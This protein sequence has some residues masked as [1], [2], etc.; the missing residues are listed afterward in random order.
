MTADSCFE[1]RDAAAVAALP[2]DHP[3]RRHAR[4]CPRCA[5]LL[6][7]WRAF[8]A[9]DPGEVSARDLADADARLSRALASAIGVPATDAATSDAAASR[10]P[11]ARHADRTAPPT[12]RTVARDV[13][14]DPS[15]W[16]RLMHPALRPALSFAALAL[17]LGAVLLWPRLA[18]HG[19]DLVLRGETHAVTLA[20][21][22]TE[23]VGEALH[24]EWRAYPGAETYEL[25]FFSGGLA[26]LGR[27]GSL[28]GT[29]ADLP[30]A[31]LPFR[32]AAGE[33]VLVRVAAMSRGDAMATS[34]ARMV[35]GR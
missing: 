22:R 6:D 2:D 26:E 15:F 13:G 32:F 16:E 21:L 17:V 5:A 20:L 8:A 12:G 23:R 3:Q 10:E 7:A 31:G 1:A 28:H 24:L 33:T 27:V 9:A 11:G 4:E 29:R 14:R 34:D 18:S 25:R 19:R 30:V 35:E